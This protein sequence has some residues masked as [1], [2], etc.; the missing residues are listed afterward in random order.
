[1]TRHSHTDVTL[2]PEEGSASGQRVHSL[3]LAAASPLLASLLSADRPC[4]LANHTLAVQLPGVPLAALAP[5]CALLYGAAVVVNKDQLT[6][7]Y[8]LG[9]GMYCRLQK[10]IIKW[11]N[12][13]MHRIIRP[14]LLSGI[15][16][17]TRLPCRI[18]GRISGKAGYRISGYC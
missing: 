2:I 12:I 1:L 8:Q 13:G 10:C 6:H 11:Y 7:I 16:P 14:F 3:L 9:N 4:P 18:F 17:D 15:R 5:T